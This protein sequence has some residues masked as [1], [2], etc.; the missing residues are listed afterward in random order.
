MKRITQLVFVAIGLALVLWS[1]NK[2]DDAVPETPPIQMKALING[3]LWTSALA[4][5]Y[6]NYD[7]AHG[8]QKLIL[9]GTTLVDTATTA[10]NI[11]VDSCKGVGT[12]K[13]T[14]SGPVQ[15]SYYH[16]GLTQATSGIVTIENFSVT[17]VKGTYFFKGGTT[18]ITEGVFNLHVQ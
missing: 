14:V 6:I 1:C 16:G 17:Q 15:A 13:I 18:T 3:G 4:N 12:Y 2:S 8:T 10:I 7:T 5:A 11:S 9:S